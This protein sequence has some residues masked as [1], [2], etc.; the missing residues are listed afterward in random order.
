MKILFDIGHPAHFHLFK[1]FIHELKN[2][3]IPFIIT[4]RD[5]DITNKLI[6]HEGFEY[7][8]LSKP[9]K[10]LAGML[11]ELIKRDMGIFKLHRQH[12]FT[13]ALG[14][15][16]SIAHLSAVSCVKS[17]NFNED[18]DDVVPLY[19]KITYPFTTKI[20]NPD[21]IKFKKWKDKRILLPTY[22][23]LAYLHPDIFKPDE[24]ILQ[25]YRLQKKRYVILRLSALKAHHDKKENG[26]NPDLRKKIIKLLRNHKYQIVESSEEQK[27]LSIDPW[28]MHH[29]LAYAKMVISDSQTMTIEA[30][31]LGVPSIR[32][33]TF[34][35]R[36]TVIDELEKKYVLT[37]GYLPDQEE[38]IYKSLKNIFTE[39]NLEDIWSK[40]RNEFLKDKINLYEWIKDEF[41]IT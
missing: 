39:H 32:I 9:G 5:K 35:G 29:L 41:R 11:L 18:D 8:C 15:S 38:Q 31:V 28:D 14:T 34:I 19:T 33:N 1:H 3:G 12:R 2:H 26:I 24:S 36:S 27:G 23:E 20:I 6:E 25:K 17:Y 7:I 40:K 22:H 21:C 10:S 4:S 30:S 16:V 37:Y 13:H